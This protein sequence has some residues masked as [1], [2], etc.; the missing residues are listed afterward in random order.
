MRSRAHATKPKKDLKN[1]SINS[2]LVVLLLAVFWISLFVGRYSIDPYTVLL[3]M[4]AQ[5]LAPFHSV[6]HSWPAVMDTVI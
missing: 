1:L 4:T 2:I 3:I 5:I 6:Q